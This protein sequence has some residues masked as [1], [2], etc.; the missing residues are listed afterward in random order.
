[1]A[2][3]IKTPKLIETLITGAI[4]AE[5]YEVDDTPLTGKPKAYRINDLEFCAGEDAA[6]NEIVFACLKS[7]YG[8]ASGDTA[9]RGVPCIAVTFKPDGD[10]PFF[11]VPLQHLT[12]L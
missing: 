6:L 5:I 1:M 10:Y 8:C 9:A 3:K 2:I 11:T 4:I 7:D 12:P